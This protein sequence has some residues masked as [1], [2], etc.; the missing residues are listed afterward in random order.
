MVGD[1]EPAE[2]REA[3]A[4]RQ[5][6]LTWRHLHTLA[7]E[8]LGSDVEARRIV[9]RTSGREGPDWLLTLDEP[10]PRRALSFFDDMVERRAAGEPLQYVLRRWGFRT[11]DLLVDRRVLIPRPETEVVVE[12]AIR[13]LRRVDSQCPLVGD[14][15]TGSGAI[16]LSIAAEVPAVHVW[17][18]DASADALAVA[19]ANL[20]GIGSPAAVRV[21]LA[22]GRWFDA[23]PGALHGQ[24]D[25]I[26]SNPPYIAEHEPLPPEVADW[27][28]RAALIAGPTGTEAV[29]EIVQGAGRWF[30]PRGALVV[31]IAPHQA[32][33]VRA[34]ARAA[35]FADVDVRPDLNG[36]A[37][38]LVARR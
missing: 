20:A 29:A 19:R 16:A 14:L 30:G 24:F 12:V 37:R 32:D 23:L 26:V 5:A 6:S 11:L 35:G 21:R 34:L 13:E 7:T 4:S 38:V 17:A 9:E 36:R 31:E 8:R 28:P 15:G 25:V 27:E 1:P 33:G 3:A 22:Q 2:L 10:V 18:T